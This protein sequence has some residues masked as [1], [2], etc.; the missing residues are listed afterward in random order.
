MIDNSLKL[1]EN[2]SSPCTDILLSWNCHL[3]KR[4]PFLTCHWQLD[5]TC[6]SGGLEEGG[7]MIDWFWSFGAQGGHFWYLLWAARALVAF[8]A[9]TW[10]LWVD[11][12]RRAELYGPFS[13]KWTQTF[14]T[15]SSYPESHPRWIQQVREKGRKIKA[16]IERAWTGRQRDCGKKQ[17]KERDLISEREG[18]QTESC[19][20]F[21]KP[22]HSAKHSQK[23]QTQKSNGR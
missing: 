13:V 5:M 7:I 10:E 21:F 16:K 8:H 3:R 15:N 14:W 4:F 6:Y 23:F 20:V 12:V 2:L 19:K 22:C 17:S 11:F 9:V 18:D 1:E